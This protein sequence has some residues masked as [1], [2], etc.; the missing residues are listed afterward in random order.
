[1]PAGS[2]S[3]RTQIVAFAGLVMA[4][5][6]LA[7]TAVNFAVD[8][9]Q[10]GRDSGPSAAPAQ[11][12][13]AVPVDRLAGRPPQVPTDAEAVIVDRVVDGDTVRVIAPP[14]S[15]IPDGG[16][17]RVRLLNID[18]PELARGGRMAECGAEEA[19]A[20]A[21]AILQPADL[22]WVAAD[23]RDR[24]RFDRPLRAMWTADGTFV[25]EAIVAAGWATAVLFPPDDRYYAAMQAAERAAAASTRGIWS[26]CAQQ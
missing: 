7:V 19:R 1:M 22:V 15:S 3:V 26:L 23:V 2:R 18:A 10:D 17:I 8:W 9:L 4:V 21:A 25:N 14:D 13:A 20:F 16:A 24:D 11:L 12:D 6:F 5:A